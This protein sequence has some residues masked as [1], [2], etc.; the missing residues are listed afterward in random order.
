[1]LKMKNFF[2]FNEGFSKSKTSSYILSLQLSNIGYSYVIVDPAGSRYAAINHHN[3][4]KKLSD[5]SIVEKAESML[6]EDLFLSKNYKNVFFSVIESKST[7]VP[8]ELFDRKQ[9]K[10]YFTFN[11][12]LDDFEELHFNYIKNAG[13]YNLFAIPSDITTLMVN[14]FPEII[15]VHHNNVF[16]NDIITRA[17][18]LKFKLPY[19]QIN[20]NLES[21]D[22]GIYK[23]EKLQVV[24]TYQFSN[25]NDFIYYLLNTINQYD[26]KLTKA[27]IN[28]SGYI[29]KDTEFYYFIH[30]YLPKINFLKLNTGLVFNFK[31]VEEHFFYNLLNLHNEDY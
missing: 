5:K 19:I 16:V 9:I 31:D 10:K 7:L 21:F 28:V 8:K 24:N 27:Y 30:Q 14:K 4:D 26:I 29:E 23:D 13:V 11:Q 17:K 20:V 25:D 2:V 12:K 3:F 15:F 6:K 1:M 22:I 18:N